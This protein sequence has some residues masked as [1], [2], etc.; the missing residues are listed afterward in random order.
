[1]RDKV[2]VL[3]Y[4]DMD[5]SP[6]TLKKCILFFDEIHFMDRPALTIG[7]FGLIG[8]PS[9][10]RAVE[11]SFREDAGVPLY[12]HGVN[13]GVISAD[14]LE[15]VKSDLSDYSFI[16]NYRQGLTASNTFRDQQVPEGNYGSFGS[17]QNE[18][19]KLFDNIDSSALHSLQAID[20]LEMHI[21]PFDVSNPEAVRAFLLHRIALCSAQI[22]FALMEGARNGFKP[23]ADAHPY[24]NLLNSQYM[25][26]V[27]ML[28]ATDNKISVADL[29]FAIFDALIANECIENMDIKDV[30]DYRKKS[31]K[32]REE[33][34][35]Y[36]SSIQSRQAHI[37][38]NEDYLGEIRKLI[39][40]EIVP[41]VTTFR[42][43]L[44]TIGE[45]FTSTLIK[46]VINGI[47]GFSGVHI[48][49][50][51]SWI[52]LTAFAG[53][54]GRYVLNAAVDNYFAERALRRECSIS[55]VL[56]LEKHK[57]KKQ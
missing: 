38:L 25:R 23:L 22:N 56:S 45:G 49:T 19:I 29:S 57:S 31:E 32:A 40:K 46:G 10:L 43:K 50:D 1:M 42:K 47:A 18:L 15:K 54:T 37:P 21:S 12:V 5:V 11:K 48:F 20:L 52:Q 34:L 36:L 13:G 33:F 51:I 24:A 55:Y 44:E 9:P 3:Y 14:L 41:A 2:N 53:I 39:D 6:T 26:A 35:E 8:A 30:V 7:N 4:P 28:G 27:N 17:N 16:E